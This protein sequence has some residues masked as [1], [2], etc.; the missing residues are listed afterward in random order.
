MINN[1][2]FNYCYDSCCINSPNNDIRQVHP[3]SFSRIIGL[4]NNCQPIVGSVQLHS[5][6][7]CGTGRN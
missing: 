3:F 2:C 7:R 6:E 5:R 4:Q 1:S